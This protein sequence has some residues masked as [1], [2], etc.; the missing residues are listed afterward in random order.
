MLFF[1]G[2]ISYNFW[3]DPFGVLN[4]NMLNQKTEPNQ[5]YLKVKYCIDNPNKYDC[6]L[7]GSSRVGKINV[8]KIPD[9]NRWYNFTYSEAIPAE[10]YKDLKI[11]LKNKVRIKKI[12]IGL[13]E[14]SYMV[15][16][17]L[18]KNQF[19][20][21]PYI[22]LF[23]PYIEYVFL[24]PNQDIYNEIKNVESSDFFTK[25]SYN[26]LFG[27]GSFLP[28]KKDTFIEKNM[29]THLNDTIFNSA[30]WSLNYENRINST[31]KE[32]NDIITLCRLNKIEVI[33]FINPIYEI[34]YLK[35]VENGFFDFYKDL[36]SL[37]QFYDFSGITVMTTNRMNYYENSH[38][39]PIIGDSIL[40]EIFFLKNNPNIVNNKNVDFF[41]EKKHK[42]ISVIKN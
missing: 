14:F 36:S 26:I 29:L 34:T 32:I 21:K 23:N 16:P 8:E 35:A 18:H 28:N 20:R 30:Y 39:R 24:K 1:L 9:S 2:I 5:H 31:I 15:S 40:Q 33:V 12:M 38:Y 13:D 41:I 22:N 10:T 3:L 11:L 27:S 25:G 42:E 7:F 6:F 37:I 4:K 19:L 17:E